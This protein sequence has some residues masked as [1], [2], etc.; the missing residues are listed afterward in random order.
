VR[1]PRERL[2]DILEAIDAIERYARRGRDAFD[3]DELIRT[4]VVYHLRIIG[5]AARMLPDDVR[6]R[7]PDIPWSQVIG[8]RHILVHGYHAVDDDIVWDAVQHGLPPLQRAVEGLLAE[9]GGA[10][11]AA[12][13]A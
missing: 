3:R 11:D 9:L 13:D 5:E 7:A 2:R 8:M 4:W 12:D 6:G 10:G 1:D